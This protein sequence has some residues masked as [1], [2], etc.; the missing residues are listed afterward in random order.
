MGSSSRFHF[1][2]S[3]TSSLYSA[4]LRFRSLSMMFLDS[5]VMKGSNKTRVQF[6][7]DILVKYKFST[8]QQI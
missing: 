3:K 8:I 5:L 2:E 7:R 1:T 4:G 6:I